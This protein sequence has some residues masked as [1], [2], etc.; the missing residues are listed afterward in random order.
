[1]KTPQKLWQGVLARV[2][3]MRDRPQL[4]ERRSATESRHGIGIL[5][6]R[7]RRSF[8]GARGQ[9]SCRWNVRQNFCYARDAPVTSLS[10][11][12]LR[13]HG[14]TNAKAQSGNPCQND[15]LQDSGKDGTIRDDSRVSPR[16]IADTKEL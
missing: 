1:M 8:T 13:L 10:E 12:M 15:E 7:A 2:I 14:S 6:V 4:P 11:R 5:A 3:I 16:A 9:G